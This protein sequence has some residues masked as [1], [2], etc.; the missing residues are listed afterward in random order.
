L[1]VSEAAHFRIAAVRVHAVP[2]VLQSEHWVVQEAE[3]EP[4]LHA[5]HALHVRVPDVPVVQ[6]HTE[7]EE[8]QVKWVEVS[9]DR[10][11]I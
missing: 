11:C 9:E 8:V 10:I 1:V 3:V 4:A 5:L 7:A 2:A 6:L